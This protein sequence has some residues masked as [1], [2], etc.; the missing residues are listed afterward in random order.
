[1]AVKSTVGKFITKLEVGNG[2]NLIDVKVTEGGSTDAKFWHQNIQIPYISSSTRLDR[3]WNWPNYIF[4]YDL[5][6]RFLGRNTVY[7]QINGED[8][9]GNA[10]PVG[11]LLISDG[12]PF[13]PD[14]Y[15][16]CVFLWYLSAAPKE[17]LIDY[18]LPADLRIL[19]ALADTA[20][21]FSFQ[22]GYDGLLTLHA[23]SSNKPAEDSQLFGKYQSVG[24]VPYP[25][26]KRIRPLRKNDGRYFYA[27]RAK[28]LALTAKL[29]YLR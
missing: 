14:K 19:R 16:P 13:F 9:H 17:A 15:Q 3:N 7:F 1:M 24:L 22:R 21:Q 29:N 26:D 10:F 12:Y 20:I 27:D 6:E 5:M 11:Q 28:S 8:A 2:P 18:G 23:A 25:A 4:W